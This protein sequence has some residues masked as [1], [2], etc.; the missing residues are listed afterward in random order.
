MTSMSTKFN[1][2]IKFVEHIDSLSSQ[3]YKDIITNT[4]DELY[5]ES[6]NA[7][8]L[9]NKLRLFNNN[10]V[11]T[12][13]DPSPFATNVIYPKI[14]Y[15]ERGHTYGN[16]VVIVIPINYNGF[17]DSVEPLVDYN[18]SNIENK[19]LIYN[20]HTNKPLKK[21]IDYDTLIKFKIIKKLQHFK[22][23]FAHELIHAYHY[24]YRTFNDMNKHLEEAAVIYGLENFSIKHKNKKIYITENI[25]RSDYGFYPRISHNF[26]R[27]L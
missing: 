20:L 8:I 2:R 27:S 15:P 19:S 26:E 24:F 13:K 22:I 23:Y 25:I 6:Q 9:M 3:E 10:I 5:S 12:N 18:N 21:E 14:I 11:I 17:I 16:K 7:A 1:P 4:I